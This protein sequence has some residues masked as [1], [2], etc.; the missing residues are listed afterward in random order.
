MGDMGERIGTK[1]W[2]PTQADS[3]EKRGGGIAVDGVESL[4]RDGIRRRLC[5][6]TALRLVNW[7][8]YSTFFSTI[9]PRLEIIFSKMSAEEAEGERE[10]R[11]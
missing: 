7:V 3:K 8:C 2:A 11:G 1:S 10:K 5:F 4:F 6:W 9:F